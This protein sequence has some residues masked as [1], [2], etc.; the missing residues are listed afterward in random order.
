MFWNLVKANL[1]GFAILIRDK[2]PGYKR[3]HRHVID[4]SVFRILAL[5]LSLIFRKEHI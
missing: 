4:V 1:S 3:A 2:K 5:L